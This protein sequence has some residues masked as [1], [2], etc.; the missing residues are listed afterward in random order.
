[1]QDMRVG[2]LGREEFPGEGN[3]YPPQCWKL[4]LA[5][6]EKTCFL[7]VTHVQND[8]GFPPV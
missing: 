2:S 6:F 1:M 7:R 4:F 3:G 5:D 8:P